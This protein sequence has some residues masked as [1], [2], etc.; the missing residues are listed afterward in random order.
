MLSLPFSQPYPVIN[1]E[2]Q[3]RD[4]YFD[5]SISP[6]DILES[7]LRGDFCH[8]VVTMRASFI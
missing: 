2:A 8:P 4:G 7:P 6:I 3:K 1:A 5:T